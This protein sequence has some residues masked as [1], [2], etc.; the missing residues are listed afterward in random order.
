ME[1][2]ENKEINTNENE[3]LTLIF[4]LGQYKVNIIDIASGTDGAPRQFR[5]YE[6][7]GAEG[8]IPVVHFLHGF[9]LKHIYF[10]DMLTHLSSHGFIV[11]S[12]QSEHKLIKGD[13]SI[14]EAQKVYSFIIW[15]KDHLTSKISVIPDFTNLGVSGHSRGG[16]VTNRMLNSHPELAVSF[17]GVDPVDSAPPMG[18]SSDPKSLNDPVQ[19][20]GESMFVGTEKGPKG[21]F[22]FAPKGDNSVSFYAGYPSPSHHIIAADVGHIDMIDQNDLSSLGLVRFACSGASDKNIKAKFINYIGGLMAAFFS[23]TLKGQTKYEALLNDAS[24]HPFKTTLVE[25]K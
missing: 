17:F 14:V 10:D 7:I 24:N 6:P 13:T 20:K 4:N 9:Q 25:H 19:F 2:T 1:K 21:M 11:V 16:K 5:I 18:S 12:G 22:S 15:L 3:D 8:K 23:S